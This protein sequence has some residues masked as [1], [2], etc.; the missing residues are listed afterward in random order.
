M[1]SFRLDTLTKQRITQTYPDTGP[2]YPEKKRKHRSRA[3]Y[4]KRKVH[5]WA[6]RI[7][8]IRR[9]TGWS[10]KQFAIIAGLSIE[11]VKQLECVKK[12]RSVNRHHKISSYY[13]TLKTIRAIRL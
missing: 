11:M 9:T 13:P 2:L 6:R 1:R 5:P 12:G 4:D 3:P 10:Q 7:I 8:N